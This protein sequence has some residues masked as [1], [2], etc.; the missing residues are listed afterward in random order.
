MLGSGPASFWEH[1]SIANYPGEKRF[2]HPRC[3]TRSILKTEVRDRA[4]GESAVAVT[5]HGF[6]GV[7]R[8]DYDNVLGGD[9]RMHAVPVEWTE[10]LPVSRTSEMRLTE[11]PAPT[12]DFNRRAAAATASALRRSITSYLAH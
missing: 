7:D 2:R 4:D 11:R 1:E 5:A 8:V 10:Y 3:V 12:E 9:G 6:E